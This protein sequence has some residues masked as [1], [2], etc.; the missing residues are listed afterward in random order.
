VVGKI[1]PLGP[2]AEWG[3][4]LR[5]G[6]AGRP[7]FIIGHLDG[8]H[9]IL[10]DVGA[11]PRWDGSPIISGPARGIVLLAVRRVS[12]WGL[13]TVSADT[14]EVQQL[15]EVD[16]ELWDAVIDPDARAAYWLVGGTSVHSGVWRMDLRSRQITQVLEADPVAGLGGAILAAAKRPLGQLAASVD[17]QLAV[18]ECY[19][20]CRLRLVDLTT[21]HFEDFSPP[22]F[23]GQSL[24]GFVPSGIAF[25]GGCI[26]LPSGAISEQRCPDQDGSVAALEAQRAMGFGVELPVGWQL[27]VTRVPNSPPLG[28][29]MMAVARSVSTSEELPLRVF[30]TL[31]G[32]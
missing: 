32:Q 25:W 26:S 11:S 16:G 29:D 15:V 13:Q 10:I 1:G 21:G 28:F 23:V 4:Q 27:E 14:G 12:G 18:L 30:G 9:R 20:G 2:A 6:A 7:G 24:L 31:H 8:S 17:G 19:Q 5:T 22:A 3:G